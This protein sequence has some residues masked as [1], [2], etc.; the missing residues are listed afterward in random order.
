MWQFDFDIYYYGSVALWRGLSPYSVTGW[1]HPLPMALVFLPFAWLPKPVAYGLYLA[2]CGWLLWRVLKKKALWILLSFPGFFTLF[3]GQVDLPF[4]LVTSLLGRWALPLLLSR[5]QLAF[6]VVPY[7]LRT[8]PPKQLIKPAAVCALV[9]GLCFLI[10]P[11]WV[12]EWLAAG[13][14]SITGYERHDSSLYWLLP[15]HPSLLV[16]GA[17]SALAVLVALK[18]GERRD[19]WTFTHLLSPVTNIYSAVVL[20][21]WFGPLEVLASW[22]AILVMKGDIH[23]GAPMFVVGLCLLAR[24]RLPILLK[25]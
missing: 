4:A 3:V 16:A 8:T 7:L 13:S 25:R 22:V 9:L 15:Q 20:G 17:I 10:R 24:H 21:E 5:P 2:V 11:A 14:Q 1:F 6:V 19:S 12:S 18:L 23:N